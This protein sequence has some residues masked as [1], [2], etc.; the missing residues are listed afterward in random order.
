M[1]I[2]EGIKQ[3][4]ERVSSERRDVTLY[5]LVRESF[6]DVVLSEHNP[7][8]NEG[9]MQF[10]GGKQSKQKV[11]KVQM[12]WGRSGGAELKEQKGSHCCCSKIN[13]VGKRR[14]RRSQ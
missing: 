10:S 4:E 13:K 8:E 9:D 2:M 3:S 12:P 6:V 7:E 5:E 14:R 1:F 11:L